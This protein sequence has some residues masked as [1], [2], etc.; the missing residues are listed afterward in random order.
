MKEKLLKKLLTLFG[1]SAE[2]F[3]GFDLY[4]IEN[5]KVKGYD[6]S[7]P[8]HELIQEN[9][10]KFD[11]LVIEF[12][13]I[14]LEEVKIILDIINAHNGTIRVICVED[15]DDNRKY[16]YIYADFSNLYDYLFNGE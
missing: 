2:L 14:N 3:Y 8:S 10:G 12:V 16:H 15:G 7:N 6:E 1:K 13:G 9:I 4:E 5:G 11:K